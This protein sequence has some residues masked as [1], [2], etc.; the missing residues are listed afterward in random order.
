ME[1]VTNNQPA[2]AAGEHI[3]GLISGHAGD[4][5]CLLSGGSALDVVE[6]IDTEREIDD[7]QTNK[8]QTAECRTIFMMGDERVSGDPMINNSLQL[9]ARY[10]WHR[11]T[12]CFVP[13]IPEPNESIEDFA[14]R[15]ETNFEKLFSELHDPLVIALLGIGPDGHTAG[16][17]PLPAQSFAEVYRDDR[18]YVPVHVEGLRI[19]SRASFTPSWLL[20]HIG[21]VV[22]Y[23]AGEGKKMILES[24]TNETKPLPERPA[25][26]LK[27]HKNVRIY[28]DVLIETL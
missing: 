4:V 26:I 24:L 6:Y 2:K 15:I 8:T 21:A 28:T 27:L 9:L 10:P 25:E 23:A 14:L 3:S 1:T 11:V 17:F 12:Q 19:D 20:A 13:T 5:L 16:I 22:G 7:P 18:T